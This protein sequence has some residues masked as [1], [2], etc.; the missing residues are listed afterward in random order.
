MTCGTS[1]VFTGYSGIRHPPC[2]SYTHT[3]IYSVY[4]EILPPLISSLRRIILARIQIVSIFRF[5]FEPSLN[6]EGMKLQQHKKRALHVWL[7]SA[8]YCFKKQLNAPISN[9]RQQLDS[10][11]QPSIYIYH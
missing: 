8:R 9:A 6:S 3:H 10:Q 4:I 7:L 2:Y 1:V 11:M 5:R